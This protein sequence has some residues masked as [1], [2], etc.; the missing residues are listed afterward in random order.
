MIVVSAA[1]GEFGRLVIDRLLDRLPSRE[2]AVAVRNPQKAADLAE[3]GVDVRYGDYDEPASLRAAFKGADR[4]LFISS[5]LTDVSGG[6]VAQHRAVAAAARDV[7]VGYIAYTSGLGADVVDEG[8]LREHRLTEQ[9]ILE[10]GLP[11]TLLRH[12]IYSDFSSTPT[13]G[14]LSRPG[15]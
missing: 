9:A 4:L 10:S 5:P 11:Y 12:P 1:T 8:V 7:K 14:P 13:F 2:L 3:R 6:R 15:S